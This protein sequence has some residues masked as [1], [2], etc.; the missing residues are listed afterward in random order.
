M[1]KRFATNPENG[2]T[3][4]LLSALKEDAQNP[5]HCLVPI[6]FEKRIYELWSS[7][8]TVLESSSST[9]IAAC[10]TDVRYRVNEAVDVLLTKMLTSSAMIVYIEA[11]RDKRGGKMD[12]FEAGRLTTLLHR[13]AREE[14]AG[15]IAA[16]AKCFE[17]GWGCV[18]DYQ[19]AAQYYAKAQEIMG[20][21][22]YQED[23]IR[24]E[25]IIE[26]S[27]PLVKMPFWR[28]LIELLKLWFWPFS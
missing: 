4:E 28:K 13:T 11:F 9:L 10:F 12:L 25:R 22:I 5:Q 15:D 8:A 23:I 18:K 17:K 27:K 14:S 21:P 6:V 16:I 24:V 2:K 20:T 3:K 7:T 26:D 19:S 1:I